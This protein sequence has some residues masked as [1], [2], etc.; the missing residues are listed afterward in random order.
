MSCT[1]VFYHDVSGETLSLRL[2]DAAGEMV[3]GEAPDSL[4]EPDSDAKPF[5]YEASVAE[6]LSGWFTAQIFDEDEDLLYTGRVKVADDEGSYLIDDPS[7]SD[8]SQSELAVGS[9]STT[10]LQQL[11]GT[12]AIHIA[13]PALLGRTLTDPL[14]QGDT[15]SAELDSAIEFSRSDF[16]DIAEESTC[17][18]IARKQDCSD[19][20]TFTISG[21]Q[22]SI[23]VRTGAK[24]CRFEPTAEQTREWEP[25]KYEFNVDV[26]WPD[27]KTRTFVGPNV[28]L[29]VIGDVQ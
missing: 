4:T 10:A 29:R 8:A 25:G 21:E 15:Y 6:D 1:V 24:V 11:A 13:V 22:A 7:R 2:L 19:V 27:G 23:P 18:L 14:I 3:N 28:F 26:I 12:R 9:L 5:R 17:R 20:V 16:P